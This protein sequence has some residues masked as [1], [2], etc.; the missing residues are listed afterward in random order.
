METNML[1]L[2]GCVGI[3]LSKQVLAEQHVVGGKQGWDESTDFDSWASGQ[4]FRVGDTLVF[5]Y[6]PLH[7]VAEL[8]SESDY[9]NCD[10]GSA[11]N[12]M[13]DGNSVVK[14][15]KEGTRYFACATSGHCAQGMKLKITTVSSS[16]PSSSTTTSSSTPTSTSTSTSGATCASDL[17]ALVAAFLVIL[18]Y[19]MNILC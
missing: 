18:S 4:T 5:K 2:V 17:F 14:L 10:V 13:S 3:L 12:S 9:K 19:L 1:L 6:S 15:T 16:S 8:G 11:T 7:N